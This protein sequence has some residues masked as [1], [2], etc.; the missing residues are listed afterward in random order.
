[1]TDD[2]RGVCRRELE[3]FVDE[4]WTDEAGNRI[5]HGYEVIAREAI[6]E[7][8]EV[9]VDFLLRPEQVARLIR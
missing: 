6:S 7:M 3:M 2:D 9:L 8:A 1:M 4:I 5:G